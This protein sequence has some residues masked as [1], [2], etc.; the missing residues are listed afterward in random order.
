MGVIVNA[1]GRSEGYFTITA[2]L[3]AIIFDAVV[4]EQGWQEVKIREKFFRCRFA[5]LALVCLGLYGVY[6]MSFA[7]GFG[8]LAKSLKSGYDMTRGD[9]NFD[10]LTFSLDEANAC[11]WIKEHTD[12]ETIV[13]N[14]RS[15]IGGDTDSY[16]YS[17]FSE[18][19]S[20]FEGA[21]LL[22]YLDL[23]NKETTMQEEADRRMN[24]AVRL[25]GN[26]IAAIEELREDGVR[27]VIQNDQIT[28]GFQYKG[29]LLEE[30]YVSGDITVYEIL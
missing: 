13:I 20:Y 3:I 18:R 23:D 29:E 10:E 15:T 22:I 6:Y 17:C 1:G 30:R 19:S 11:T 8:G 2:S 12:R 4:I 21:G 14:D 24:L 5:R 9:G 16:Y 7:S 28:P 27:Y 25:Y 26:D